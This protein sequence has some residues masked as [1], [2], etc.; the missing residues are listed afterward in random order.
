MKTIGLGNALIDVLLRLNNDEVLTGIGIQKGSM[1]LINREKMLAIRKEQ[2]ALENSMAPGGSVSNTMRA[3]AEL[4]AKPGY[5]GKLGTDSLGTFYEKELEKAGVTTHF[6]KVLGESGSSTVLISPDGERTMATFLGPAE[7]LCA[8][9]LMEEII[10]EYDCIYIEG[11]LIFNEPLVRR[12]MELGKKNGLWIALDLASFNVV[13]AKLD[14][15]REI[16]PQYVDI[17]FSNESEAEMFTGLPAAQ[18]VRTIAKQVEISVVT[19]GKE[20]AFIGVGEQV[21]TIPTIGTTPVDTTGAGDHFAAG[22]LYGFTR[23]A[24][25]KQSGCIGALLAGNIIEVVGAKIPEERWEQIK[26][27]VNDILA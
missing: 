12:A 5:I 7:T 18:A 26:L 9:E 21:I 27:K 20:G 15:L 2:E 10:S 3:M 6:I 13:E 25:V 23:S 22:F 24:S 1:E 11:Y 16:V 17:L 14:F 19:L 4:G 8:D